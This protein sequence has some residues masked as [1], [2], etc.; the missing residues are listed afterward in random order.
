MTA[1][2]QKIVM[3]TNTNPTKIT[4]SNKFLPCLQE[5]LDG[6]CR[7]DP[8]TKKK[9]PVEVDVPELLFNMG[10]SPSGT[11]PGQVV[12]DLTLIAFYYLL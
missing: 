3:D 12:G 8:P 6:Y 5:L 1:I 11:T 2:G 4:G 10:Y 9:L 7:E